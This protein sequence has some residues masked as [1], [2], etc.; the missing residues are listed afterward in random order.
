MNKFKEE[1]TMNLVKQGLREFPHIPMGVKSVDVR[2]NRIE[3]ISIPKDCMIEAL[4]ISDNLIRSLESVSGTHTLE[5]LDAGYNLIE[6]LPDLDLPNLRELYLM[7]NDV[8]RL[9]NVNFQMLEK[10]DVANNDI[11][12][13]EKLNCPNLLEAYFG[14]NQISTLQDMNDLRLLKILDLQYNKLEE[15]DCALIPESLEVLLLQGNKM[16]KNIRNLEK[17][18]NLKVLGLKNTQIGN[19]EA[20]EGLEIW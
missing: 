11:K 5:V 7:S 15:L 20:R 16:L 8:A 10:L 12:V 4:D 13:L 14:A 9:G 6:E 19:I 17:L 18:R 2:R 3:T 1:E